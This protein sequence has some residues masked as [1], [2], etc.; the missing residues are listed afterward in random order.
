MSVS[1]VPGCVLAGLAAAGLSA[2]ATTAG[3]PPVP[4]PP[5]TASGFHDAAYMGRVE[6]LAARRGIKVQWVNPPPRPSRAVA[7]V[8]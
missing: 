1:R 7:S 3:P 6:A 4:V 8:D 5:S 2:C